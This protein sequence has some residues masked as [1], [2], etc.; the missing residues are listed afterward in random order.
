MPLYRTLYVSA[1]VVLLTAC[2]GPA[3]DVV[4]RIPPHVASSTPSLL[5]RAASTTVDVR[6]IRET[7]GTGVLPGRIGERKT[8]GNLSLGAVTITP[9]PGEV[10]TDALKSEL[11]AAGHRVAADGASVV[12]DGTIQRFDLRTD[13]T[14]LYWDIIG[15]TAVLVNVRSDGRS[16]NGQYTATCKERTYVWPTGDLIAQVISACV[17][18]IARQFREDAAVVHALG[19]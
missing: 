10:V 3:G 9:V 8:I 18:D 1:I 6:D 19:G 16:A 11:R 13:V 14:A 2:A 17:D 4:V 12:I 5:S 7:A 15:T